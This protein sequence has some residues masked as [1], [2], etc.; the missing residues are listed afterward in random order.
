MESYID[1]AE[2]AHRFGEILDRVRSRQETFVVTGSSG[3]PICQIT[4]A[5]PRR[6][7]TTTDLADLLD[8]LPRPDPGFADDLQRV[9]DEQPVV[10]PRSAWD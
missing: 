4:P 6:R 10:V 7:F 2:A 8:R 1:A 3:E 9:I 5:A